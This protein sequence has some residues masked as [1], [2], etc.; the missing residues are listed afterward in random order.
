[1]GLPGSGFKGKDRVAGGEMVPG[2]Q[3]LQ[4]GH[5]QGHDC[6]TENVYMIRRTELS[7]ISY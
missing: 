5:D 3:Y 4:R 7:G 2:H 1:M 6:N